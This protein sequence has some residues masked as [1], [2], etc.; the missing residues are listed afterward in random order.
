VA[1]AV[2]APGSEVDMLIQVLGPGCPKCKQLAQNA[3][4]AARELALDFRLEKV[5]DI[6]QITGFG[7]LLTPAL[8]VDGQVRLQGK[9]PGVEE[10][11]A[12][13]A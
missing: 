10:V 11:K 1:G 12:L 4:A 3:E 7:V 8:V 13:L 5:T 2:N 6:V 9:C